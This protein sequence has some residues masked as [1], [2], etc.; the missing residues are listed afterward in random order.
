ME[1]FKIEFKWA[2]YLTF[3]SI[4]W[5]QLENKLGWHSQ[6][7][8]NLGL[9]TNLKYIL[10]FLLFIAAIYNKKTSYFK[11]QMSWQQGLVSGVIIAILGTLLAPFAVY[12]C[13][14]YISPNY[15]EN[16]TNYLV[17]VGATKENAQLMYNQ[18]TQ[19][20]VEAFSTLSFGIIFA[21]LSSY[22]LFQKNK[23]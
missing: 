20:F 2:V 21:A 3:L 17:S 5:F 12:F 22:I 16:L 8:K 14:K 11:N 9:L 1:K 6:N 15:F 4:V 18:K 7:I 19:M 13:I 23:K 10:V